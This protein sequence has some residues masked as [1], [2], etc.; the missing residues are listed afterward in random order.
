MKFNLEFE[1]KNYICEWFDKTDFSKFKKDEVFQVHGF[2]FDDEGKICLVDCRGDGIYTTPGGGPEDIDKSFE[3]TLKREIREEVDL[4]VKELIPLGYIKAI[5]SDKEKVIF[6]LRYVGKVKEINKQTIDPAHERI[7]ERVFI[8][9]EE[10]EK[11]TGWGENG[12]LQLNK[13]LEKL[14][15]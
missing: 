3:E 15:Q 6:S 11:Y 4:E 14:K 7:P 5:C 9:P 12:Q 10:F 13:A 1:G 2:I 8:S